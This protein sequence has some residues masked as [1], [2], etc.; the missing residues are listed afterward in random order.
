L[1]INFL[2]DFEEILKFTTCKISEIEVSKYIFSSIMCNTINASFI[3]GY[4]S[5]R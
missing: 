2:T 1:N 4:H 5:W 3:Y